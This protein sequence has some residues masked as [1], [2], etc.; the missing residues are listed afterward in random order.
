MKVEE[1]KEENKI[2]DP[3]VEDLLKKYYKEKGKESILKKDLKILIDQSII[4]LSQW[5]KLSQ[6]LKSRFPI[7]LVNGLDKIAGVKNEVRKI[8]TQTGIRNEI[9]QNFNFKD[10]NV[11]YNNEQRGKKREY[12][13]S[14]NSRKKLRVL[15]FMVKIKVWV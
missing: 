12:L 14:N 8:K 6:E 11:H 13:G 3:K 4:H 9:E 1:K 5:K 2:V 7:V 15:T 10:R